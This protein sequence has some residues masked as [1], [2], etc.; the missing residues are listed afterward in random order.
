MR[1]KSNIFISLIG[2]VFILISCQETKIGEKKE[3]NFNK[4]YF[5]L[6]IDTTI[7]GTVLCNDKFVTLK[8]NGEFIC[9]NTSDFN[10]DTINTNKL[11]KKKCSSFYQMY[12]SLIV[13]E[14]DRDYFVNSDF[15]FIPYDRNKYSFYK[16]DTTTNYNNNGQKFIDPLYCDSNFVIA[17]FCAGEF[18]GTLYFFDLKDNKEYYCPATCA[19][20]VNKIEDKYI[21]TN[22]LAH[23]DGSSEVLEITK[24]KS[25]IEL[26]F[27]TVKYWGNFWY[28]SVW[29]GQ[30]LERYDSLINM[31]RGENKQILDTVG[32]LIYTSFKYQ[33]GIFHI[34]RSTGIYYDTIPNPC[35]LYIGKIENNK[36]IAVD[37]LCDVE[38]FTYNPQNRVYNEWTLYSYNFRGKNTGFIAIKDNT[39]NMIEFEIKKKSN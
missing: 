23:M 37:S 30:S 11:N 15:E 5:K 17:Q 9:L 24:P 6:D 3:I 18:G 7:F 21:V 31:I 28:S 33:K 36:L 39:I 14:N 10:T 26:D 35:D 22:S 38:I 1:V 27:D 20:A 2:L 8:S 12:D 13:V 34:Y 16:S 4:R 25:L 19:T 29:D 32:V